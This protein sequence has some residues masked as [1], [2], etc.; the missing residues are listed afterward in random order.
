MRALVTGWFSFEHG[1]ATAGDLRAAEVVCGWL[2]EAGIAYDVATSPAFAE[3]I[4]WREADPAAYS[5]L[6]FACGP[7]EGE[8]L[9]ALV[10]RFRDCRRTAVDVSLTPGTHP[11]F[12]TVFERDGAGTARPDVAIAS[13]RET[14]P[15]VGVVRAHAQPEYHGATDL[16]EVH[17]TIDRALAGERV[18]IVE[19]DTRVDPREPG[20]Q[21]CAQVE[22]AIART[23]AVVTTRLHG[24]VMALKGGTPALAVDPVHG[25][26]KV[27]GQARA[28]GWPHVLCVDDLHVDDLRSV[29][30]SCLDPDARRRAVECRDRAHEQVRRL[31]DEVVRS[32]TGRHRGG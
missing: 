28:L 27:T 15:V 1:E 22:T 10:D 17:A 31:G 6:V 2:D 26:G 29:L 24:L 25:G 9:D 19:L 16:D 12:E 8:Q 5:D 18:A 11:D 13:R 30:R 3:G 14:V 23:D 32:L 7:L 4:D 20:I 21:T